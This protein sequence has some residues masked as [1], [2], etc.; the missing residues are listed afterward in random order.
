MTT[1]DTI[2][3]I[4]SPLGRGA[5]GV[6]RVSGPRVPQ[7]AKAILGGLPQPRSAEFRRFRD[8]HGHNLDEGLVLYFP[9]PAS[10]TGEHVLELQGHGGAVVQDLL[11]GRLV[12]LGC[13]QAL[14]GEFSERAFLAGKIDVAQAEAVADLI[15]AGSTAAARAAMRSMQGDFSARVHELQSLLTDLRV[16]VEAG[17]DFPDEEID[18]LADAAL[19]ERLKRLFLSSMILA[20]PCSRGRFCARATRS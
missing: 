17:I 9:A 16:H 13:R 2:V 8:A 14:P 12:E 5:V 6:I 11:V 3:A 1:P 4:A 19:G 7:V 20:K 18:F 15:D 10:F